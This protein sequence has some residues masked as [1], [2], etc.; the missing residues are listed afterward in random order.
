MPV[1]WIKELDENAIYIDPKK[2]Y[3]LFYSVD[4]SA[5]ADFTRHKFSKNFINMVPVLYK[6]TINEIFPHSCN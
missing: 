6:V 2:V 3:L 5:E 4:S 1:R